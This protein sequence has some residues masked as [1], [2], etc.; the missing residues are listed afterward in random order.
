METLKLSKERA[1]ELFPKSSPEW[2]AI[3]IDTFGKKP[4]YKKITERINSWEDVCE[5]LDVHPYQ[6]L[7]FPDPQNS[8]E[9]GM[10][11]F[12]KVTKIREVLNSDSTQGPYFYYP[13]FDRSGGCF[14]FNSYDFDY[15]RSCVG[16]RLT[17]HTCELAEHAGRTFTDIYKDLHTL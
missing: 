1:I 4:F 16:A 3:L 15:S 11:A 14:S 6:S 12:H 7:P 9:I 2:Q 17:F 8:Y 5:A 13:V 10:N